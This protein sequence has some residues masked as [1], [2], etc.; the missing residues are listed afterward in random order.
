MSVPQIAEFF[1]FLCQELSLSVP[2]VKGYWAILSHVF[3]LT[4]MDLAASTVVSRMFHSSGRL[5]PP[6]EIRPPD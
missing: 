3:S 1:L 5:C 4:G 2:A 6:Q